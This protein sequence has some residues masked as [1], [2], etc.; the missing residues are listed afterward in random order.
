MNNEDFETESRKHYYYLKGNTHV[1]LEE[2]EGVKDALNGLPLINPNILGIKS[3]DT[4]KNKR[5][6]KR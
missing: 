6:F 1:R 2:M 3:K 4:S 5:A